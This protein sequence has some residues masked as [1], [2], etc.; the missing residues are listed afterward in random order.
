MFLLAFAEEDFTQ[1]GFLLL[2]LVLVLLL[3]V[4]MLLLLLMLMLLLLVLAAKRTKKEVGAK[5]RSTLID[6]KPSNIRPLSDIQINIELESK[7]KEPFLPHE[8]DFEPAGVGSTENSLPCKF[9]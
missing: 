3:L 1:L 5:K 9:V 4:L 7:N 8:G 6:R 2:L